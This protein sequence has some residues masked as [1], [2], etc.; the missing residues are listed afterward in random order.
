MYSFRSPGFPLSV[1][2]DLLLNYQYIVHFAFDACNV[3]LHG[4]LIPLIHMFPVLTRE[5][6]MDRCRA[7]LKL[8]IVLL[9]AILATATEPEVGTSLWGAEAAVGAS[10]VAFD[11][12]YV[13]EGFE[14]GFVKVSHLGVV[15]TDGESNVRE[16]HF[17][18]GLVLRRIEGLF[19][20][21]DDG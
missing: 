12:E 17:D 1:A 4:D 18:D 11:H 10:L 15:V 20:V 5:R 8:A 3:D 16:G 13:A 9:E 21:C 7:I 14:D 2:P 6:N 19:D